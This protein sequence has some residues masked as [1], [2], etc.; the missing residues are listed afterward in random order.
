[1]H[2]GGVEFV[3]RWSLHVSPKGYV[4]S[5]RFGGWSHRRREDYLRRCE[6]LLGDAAAPIPAPEAERQGA[7]EAA[8]P[9]CPH[10][11]GPLRLTGV[12]DR[13][14]WRD[15]LS[16]PARPTWYRDSG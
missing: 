13:P 8:S 11:Q 15:L 2:L 1:M 6:R 9:K 7:A 5:R 3:R 10:C 16:G 12:E 4:R 14:S